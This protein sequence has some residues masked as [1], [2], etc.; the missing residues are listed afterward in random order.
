MAAGFLVSDRSGGN[1]ELALSDGGS[2]PVQAIPNTGGTGTGNGILIFPDIAT[3]AAFNVASPIAL[4]LGQQAFVQSNGS[5]WTLVGGA[6]ATDGITVVNGT[7]VALA[8]WIRE[9]TAGYLQAALLQAT[10]FVDPLNGNDESSGIDTSNTI[11]T[12]A[13]MYRRFG[14]TWSQTIDGMTVGVVLLNQNPETD[15]YLFQP[16][17]VN[18]GRMVLTCD[19]AT[20]APAFTGTLLAVTPKSHAGNS[21]LKSTFT[22]TTG[23]ILPGMLFINATRGNSTSM[24]VSNAAGTWTL[25]QPLAFYDGVTGIA[26]LV[27]EV[28][29]WANGDAIQGF[30]LPGANVGRIGGRAIDLMQDF[31][32]NHIVA[33]LTLIDPAGEGNVDP[34]F[35]ESESVPL[36]FNCVVNRAKTLSPNATA[37][38]AVALGC[39]FNNILFLSSNVFNG[40]VLRACVFASSLASTGGVELSG[41]CMTTPSGVLTVGNMLEADGLFLAAGSTLNLINGQGSLGGPVYGTG[42]N[43]FVLQGTMSYNAPASTAL[44][45]TGVAYEIGESTN[46]YSNSTTAGVVTVHQVTG[47]SAALLDA[48]AGAAGYGGLAYIPGVAALT[49]VGSHP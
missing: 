49:A 46:A 13:E 21:P 44:P 33:L 39:M 18:Q 11:K 4:P 20:L 1:F 14:A 40:N 43:L 35:V 5:W 47:I 26:A 23:T 16:V 45:G 48:A 37:A 10:W 7:G 19:F 38:Q 8:Q 29:T 32:Q 31:G 6:L 2:L 24:A 27:A 9:Q 36:V 34:I 3:M 17:F 30:V 15:P 42:F 28:D 12:F 22:T 41:D 25:R